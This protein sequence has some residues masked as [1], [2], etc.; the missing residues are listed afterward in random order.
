MAHVEDKQDAIAT[1]RV[2]AEA[3]A[4]LAEFDEAAPADYASSLQD[5]ENPSAKYMELISQASFLWLEEVRFLAKTY[6]TVCSQ[7]FGA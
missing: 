2:A 5:I 3:S 6:R 7:L 1:T 4:D